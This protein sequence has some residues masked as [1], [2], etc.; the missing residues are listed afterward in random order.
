VQSILSH[1]RDMVVPNSTSATIAGIVDALA[2][3]EDGED[4]L[5]VAV[6]RQVMIRSTSVFTMLMMHGV[7]CDL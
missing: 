7:E 4:P 5:N 3:K 6:C 2:P 1:V